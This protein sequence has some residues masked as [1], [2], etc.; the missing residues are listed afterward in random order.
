MKRKEFIKKTMATGVSVLTVP[1]LIKAEQNSAPINRVGFNHLPNKEYKTMNTVLHKSATRGQVNHGWLN[2]RHSFSFANYYNPDRMNF[3][4]LRVLNDD[5]I[6]GGNGF[7]L[8]PHENMEI[9]SIPL[10]GALAH[11]DNMGNESVIKSGDI[12]VMSAGT[13]IMHSEFNHS[14]DSDV[15]LLQ[16]WLDPK[17]K[18][19]MPRYEQITLDTKKVKN[20]MHQIL[21]PNKQDDGVWIHQNAWFHL[22]NI[23]KGKQINYTLKDA[24]NGVYA[25]ILEGEV[26]IENQ[27]LNKRDGFGVW[28]TKEIKIITNS[29]SKILL[30][31]VPMEN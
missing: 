8:H 11:K 30:L 7:G 23:D 25:F 20:K 26:S 29:N 15:K 17:T 31:E 4:V 21:S 27:V 19:V 16:I 1:A 6:S 22:G 13:G 10:D 14:A 18:N 3:G 28:N 12:Q 5:V 2:A 9:I 24:Q